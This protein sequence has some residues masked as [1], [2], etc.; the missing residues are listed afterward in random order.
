MNTSQ[1]HRSIQPLA[2]QPSRIRHPAKLFPAGRGFVQVFGRAPG[3]FTIAWRE[4]GGARKRSMRSTWS[5]AKAFAE[6]K[7]VH[8]ANLQ[9]GLEQLS[10]VDAASYFRFL[11]ITRPTGKPIE[12]IA[13][14]YTE[15]LQLL[16]DAGF[17]QLSILE[18]TRFYIENR[19][20]VAT[21]QPLSRVVQEYLDER[22]GHLSKDHHHH[23]SHQLA[24][25]SAF[26][27]GP[28]HQLQRVD[29]DLWIRSLGVGPRTRCGYREAV[30]ELVR[31]AEASGYVGP[32]NPLLARGKSTR[33]PVQEIKILTIDQVT[34][35]LSIRHHDEETGR[36][37]KSLIPFLALQVFAG[38]RHSEAARLDW[39]DIHLEERSIYVPKSIGKGGRA[40]VVPISDNLAAW[41]R[42]HIRRSGPIT[43]LKQISG[44]LTKAKKRARIPAGDNETRNVLRKTFISYRKAAIQ[45]IAQVAE[46]AGNSVGIIHKHYGRPIPQAEGKRLFEIWP[47]TAGVLQLNFNLAS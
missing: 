12:L 26:Y 25:L 6:T 40:R 11:E 20:R 43:S 22:K 8:L 3:P 24:K 36:A 21:P 7:A 2:F 34:D 27:T 46:E 33:Q 28:I 17:S 41:L 31:H 42:D 38:L 9:T 10:P 29:V 32:N 4:L 30:R 5:K 19:P 1:S 16:R 15:S 14:E 35:L 44:A 39:R 23:R 18:A 37:Q 47:T 45:N 13:G